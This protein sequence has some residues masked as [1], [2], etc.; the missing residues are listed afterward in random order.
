MKE[1]EKSRRSLVFE[2]IIR[3][4]IVVLAEIVIYGYV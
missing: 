2:R 3:I 4:S 1:E